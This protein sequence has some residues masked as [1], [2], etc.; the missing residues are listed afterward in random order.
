LREEHFICEVCGENGINPATMGIE[1]ERNIARSIQL[2]R[3]CG[4]IDL[5]LMQLCG[6]IPI[7]CSDN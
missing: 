4:P 1:S 3:G 5:E 6:E 7:G 2:C